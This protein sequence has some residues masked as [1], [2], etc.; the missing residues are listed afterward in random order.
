MDG[1]GGHGYNNSVQGRE[2]TTLCNSAQS[3]LH[4]HC[5]ISDRDQLGFRSSKGGSF[6]PKVRLLP[7]TFARP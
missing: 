3:G 7:V 2:T 1:N 5:N 4:P 6:L